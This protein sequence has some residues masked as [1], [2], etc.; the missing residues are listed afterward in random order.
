MGGHHRPTVL[1]PGFADSAL[2]LITDTA[3][4]KQEPGLG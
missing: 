4:V 2:K 1:Q 3:D